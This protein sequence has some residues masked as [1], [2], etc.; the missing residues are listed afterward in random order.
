MNEI[1]NNDFK[2]VLDLTVLKEYFF[3]QRFPSIFLEM[4]IF[5]RYQH[6]CMKLLLYRRTVITLLNDDQISN[7]TRFLY[8]VIF[9][10]RIA[11]CIMEIIEIFDTF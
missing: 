2:I 6:F 3:K 11:Q 9:A 8:V 4:D 7:N 1:K 10:H 5:L